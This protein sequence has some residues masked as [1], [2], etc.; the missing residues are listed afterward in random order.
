[1][2]CYRQAGAPEGRKG[3]S[4]YGLRVINIG[5]EGQQVGP[6][7]S[8]LDKARRGG[9][10]RVRRVGMGDRRVGVR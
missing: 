1:M 9:N 10:E 6:R 2:G 4:D 8:E 5:Y 7:E 3:A